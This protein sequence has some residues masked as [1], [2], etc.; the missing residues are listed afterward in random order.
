MPIMS[1]APKR[2]VT[3]NSPEELLRSFLTGLP[4]DFR[5]ETVRL[6]V[7]PIEYFRPFLRV[8]TPLNAAPYSYL[9]VQ[10]TGKGVVEINT[11]LVTIQGRSAMFINRGSV[12]SL[13]EIRPTTTGW[14]IMFDE[15]LAARVLSPETLA[16][17]VGLQ[18]PISLSAETMRWI[19]E[20]CGLLEREGGIETT[21]HQPVSEHLFAALVER[22]FAESDGSAPRR[23]G[24]PE[25]LDRR[26]RQLVF[27][28]AAAEGSVGFYAGKLNV[29]VN[30]LMRCV[31]RTSGRSP[32]DWII[33]VRLMEAQRLL[34]TTD[35]TVGEIAA[36]VGF[37][38]PSYFGR[39]FR[40]RFGM[41]P[42][43]FRTIREHDSSE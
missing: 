7:Y 13:R 30:Y 40:R 6:Q 16:Q 34:R 33:D 27:E 20:L 19:G 41:S 8:P 1:K 17:V 32:K 9:I 37:D 11:T 21:G 31:T 18:A 28:N 29:S 22:L 14:M 3:I 42:R 23:T 2:F 35:G 24:R 43:A 26:F 5:F 15:A 38:D 25:S 39:L 4:P 10:Q 36:R 12:V